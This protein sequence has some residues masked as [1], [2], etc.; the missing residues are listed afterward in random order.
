[1][2]QVHLYAFSKADDAVGE[3][4]G[5]AEEALGSAIPRDSVSSR[6]VRL[7]APGKLMMCL[8]FPLPRDIL[9][10]TENDG[11]GHE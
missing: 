2:P 5:R 6:E 4:L 9:G 1:M 8:T 7:V 10:K 3:I 11:E